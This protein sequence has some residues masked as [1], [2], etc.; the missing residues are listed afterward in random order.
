MRAVDET[1]GARNPSFKYIDAVLKEWQEQDITT[2][3]GLRAG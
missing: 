3:E 2:P 1:I